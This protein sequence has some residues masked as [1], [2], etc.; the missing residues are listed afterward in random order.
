MFEEIFSARRPEYFDLILKSAIKEYINDVITERLK[1]VKVQIPQK[2]IDE[3]IRDFFASKPNFDFDIYEMIK[4]ATLDAIG[5]KKNGQMSEEMKSVVQAEVA[6][7]IAKEGL[8]NAIPPVEISYKET[9]PAESEEDI[10]EAA[11][12]Y[13]YEDGM[14]DGICEAVDKVNNLLATYD[15]KI[16]VGYDIDKDEYTLL[17]NKTQEEN[18]ESKCDFKDCKNFS[19]SNDLCSDCSNLKN[20]VKDSECIKEKDKNEQIDSDDILLKIIE[21]V[22]FEHTGNKLS[23][24]E[25]KYIQEYIDTNGDEYEFITSNCNGLKSLINDALENIPKRRKRK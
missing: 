15:K 1:K 16:K 6:N 11:Y 2:D 24:E 19:A 23:S 7:I 10:D 3:S 8:K 17:F 4:E 22:Y 21:D 25:I 9:V 5:I 14:F 13:A 12:A 18:K 20:T